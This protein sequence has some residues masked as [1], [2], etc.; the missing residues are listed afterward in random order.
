MYTI[1]CRFSRSRGSVHCIDQSSYTMH[2]ARAVNRYN[3]AGLFL[4]G[5]SL[6]LAGYPGSVQM[7]DGLIGSSFSLLKFNCLS[8]VENGRC[9]CIIF[10]FNWVII[11]TKHPALHF[12]PFI[13]YSESDRHYLGIQPDNVYHAT[14]TSDLYVD[15]MYCV[16][17]MALR[18]LVGKELTL[19]SPLRLTF[20]SP[21]LLVNQE[22]CPD[23][24]RSVCGKIRSVWRNCELT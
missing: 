22:S 2:N 5:R 3:L 11:P 1:E 12:K 16:H 6:L 9:D 7:I 14:T 24:C 17:R 18:S 4:L 19:A 15:I 8:E 13:S 10:F 21:H 23:V 20:H